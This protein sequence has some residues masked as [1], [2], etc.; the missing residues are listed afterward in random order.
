MMPW[1]RA[2][3]GRERAHAGV[4]VVGGRHREGDD[5]GGGGDGGELARGAQVVKGGGER[6]AQKGE[7][8][9]GEGA[10]DVR[11]RVHA[12]NVAVRA[13]HRL[14]APPLVV[15]GVGRRIVPQRAEAGLPAV[16]DGKL[17]V[18]AGGGVL[19]A[20]LD[21][22]ALERAVGHALGRVVHA[23]VR[24]QRVRVVAARVAE[25]QRRKAQPPAAGA[26]LLTMAA[27]RAAGAAAGG[28]YAQRARPAAIATGQ[29]PRVPK[30]ARRRL[31]PR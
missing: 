11:P 29:C 1:S 26:R 22:Q 30:R 2:E 31:A 10:H 28:D 6:G 8:G 16:A 3:R 14:S 18:D 17:V 15:A 24:R 20:V 27:A 21:G 25:G 13:E 4:G 19:G 7:D 23:A 12:L 5:G 9:K